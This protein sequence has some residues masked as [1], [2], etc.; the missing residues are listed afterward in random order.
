[1]VEKDMTMKTFELIFGCSETSNFGGRG[2]LKTWTFVPRTA[3]S[4]SS[5][6]EG[7]MLENLVVYDIG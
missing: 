4:A 2:R 1:M 6:P 7:E 5:E 3:G